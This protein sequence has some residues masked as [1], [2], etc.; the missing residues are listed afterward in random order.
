M[1]IKLFENYSASY[2]EL[3][4]LHLK[5][6]IDIQPITL[7]KL[8]MWGFKYT[9]SMSLGYSNDNYGNNGG[10]FKFVYL[11]NTKNNDILE[12][13]YIIEA[14]DGWFFVYLSLGRSRQT[15]RCDQLDGLYELLKNK[16]LIDETY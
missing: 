9:I 14:D 2:E 15:Y 11:K 12:D 6:C 5:G 13:S 16:G 3:P 4:N 10:E 8:S 7:H 1:K